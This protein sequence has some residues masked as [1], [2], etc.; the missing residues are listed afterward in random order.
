MA[1]VLG[2][3]NGVYPCGL[4]T[5]ISKPFAGKDCF[6]SQGSRNLDCLPHL[7]RYL[8]GRKGFNIPGAGRNKS[9]PTFFLVFTEG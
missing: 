2:K 5:L 8:S 4:R 6:H 1:V 9:M 7:N 3:Q